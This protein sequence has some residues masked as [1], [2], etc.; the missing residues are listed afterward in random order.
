[1][2]RFVQLLQVSASSDDDGLT[3]AQIL[4]DIPVDPASILSYLLLAGFVGG[5]LWFGTRGGG[6]GKAGP[7]PPAT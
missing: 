3:F 4:Q 2:Y 7:P 1:M 5:V 6:S